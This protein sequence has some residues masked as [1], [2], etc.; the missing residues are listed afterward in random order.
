MEIHAS[1]GCAQAGPAK[2]LS[3]SGF[4]NCGGE[5]PLAFWADWVC[6]HLV[7]AQCDTTLRPASFHGRIEQR[8]LP[9]MVLS[10]ITSTTQ[11]VARTRMHLARGGDEHIMVNIQRTG[12]GR[13]KQGWRSIP[14]L[15][16]MSSVLM[17]NSGKPC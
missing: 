11:K 14:A 16:P 7:N 6:A 17:R 2:S 4:V 10:Q 1:D 8:E 9:G 15:S 13:V 5:D 12:T 3:T